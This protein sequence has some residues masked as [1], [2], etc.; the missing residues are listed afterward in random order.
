MSLIVFFCTLALF[1]GLDL[2]CQV[3]NRFHH[4]DEMGTERLVVRRGQPF[5]VL[6]KFKDS[7]LHPPD[8]QITLILNLGKYAV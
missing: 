7:Q 8:H 3:N 4:T 6:L 2:Q 5:S 1:Q